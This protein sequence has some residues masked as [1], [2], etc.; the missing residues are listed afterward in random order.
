[1]II[2]DI[3]TTGID[4]KKHAIIDIGAVDFNNPKNTFSIQCKLFDGALIDEES[5]EI[6][7]YSIEEINS[8]KYSQEEAIIMFSNWIADIQGDRT[9]CA[10]NIFFDYSFLKETY[11][12]CNLLFPFSKRIL[13]SHSTMYN[14]H[15]ELGLEIP[16]DN[17]N[18]SNLSSKILANFVGLPEEPKDHKGI[19][20][21]KWEAEAY[22]RIVLGKN[23][24][25]EFKIYDIPKYL[26]K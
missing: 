15:L 21:A 20:G 13:D 11:K 22:S 1:M 9:L 17:K 12:R 16:L 23:L 24:L 4:S 18:C 2:V 8:H 10:H 19:N 3:E 6:N 5:L 26:S 7:G 25:E 14:K